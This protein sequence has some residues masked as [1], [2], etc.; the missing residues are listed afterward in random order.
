MEEFLRSM[1]L[2]KGSYADFDEAGGNKAG[3][4]FSVLVS[5]V[6]LFLFSMLLA[7]YSPFEGVSPFGHAAVFAA[8]YMGLDPYSSCLGAVIG[9]FLAHDYACAVSCIALGVGIWCANTFWKPRR[10]YRL[11]AAFAAAAIFNA[12]A[13]L[14]FRKNAI[15][16][17]ASATVSV[18]GAVVIGRGLKAIR[19]AVTGRRITEGEIV[20]LSALF[21]MISLSLGKTDV[22]G[23]SPA[24]IFSC[25]VSMLAANRLGMSAVATAAALG[26]GHALAAGAD[27]H[28]VAVMAAVAFAAASFRPL[29]KWGVMAAFAGASCFITAFVGGNGV[30]GYIECLIACGLFALIPAKLYMKKADAKADPRLSKLQYRVAAMSEVLAE[31]SRVDGGDEGVMLKNISSS[32]KRSLNANTDHK[33]QR[34]AVSFGSAT[35]GKNAGAASGDSFAVREIDGGVLIALSDGMGSGEAAK[36]ESSAAVAMLSDL[37]KVGFSLEDAAD[38]VN[39]SLAKRGFGDMYATLDAFFIDLSD[40]SSVLSKHGAPPS[41]VVH[42]TN[43]SKVS[44]EALP[45]GVIRGAQGSKKSFELEPGDAVV[46]MTD[47]VSDAL[48]DAAGMTVTRLVCESASAKASA[49]AIL[50]TALADG[51]SDDMTV[52]VAKIRGVTRKSR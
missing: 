29:G 13:G 31:L 36:K 6:L 48:G 37:M 4:T 26:A 17:A 18:L 11:P 25:L 2:D 34:M 14:I 8:W 46:M 44:S 12:S 10:V 32:L 35:R 38:C 5:D 28:F 40:G 3:I 42:G 49:E 39:S 33:K 24:V 22:F 23:Q 20:T 43:A 7:S 52:V 50:G 21:G 41:F 51:A 45:V 15:L 47:G 16:L 1:T 9:Y 19:G 27:M 30:V